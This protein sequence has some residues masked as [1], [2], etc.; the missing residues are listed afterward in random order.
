MAQ[1]TL[2]S[3]GVASNGAL[4]LQSNG[5]TAAVTIDTSQ[6]AAFVAGTAA[7]PAITTTGDTNTGIYFPAADTIAFSE[8][9]AESMRIDSS[10]NVGIGTI[11]PTTK[12]TVGT[13][14]AG[15]VDAT[16]KGNI[17]IEG[18]ETTFEAQG[19]LE[20]KMT[21]DGYGAKI[22]TISS[23][24]TNLAFATRNNSATWTERMRIDP[25]G[26]VGIGTNSP[27]SNGKL[28]VAGNIILGAPP[29]RN[30]ASSNY[31]GVA[32]T[33][34]P[35]DDNRARIVFNTVAGASSSNSNITFS[36]N[37]YGVSGGERM[38]L[39]SSGNL[40][41]GTTSALGGALFTVVGSLGAYLR[42]NGGAGNEALNLHNTA[43]SG[44]IYQ[45]TFRDGA[46]ATSRGSVTTNGTGTAY[47][48]TSDYRLKD[49]IAPMTG[50][51]D[52]VQ[53]LKPVTYNWKV[54]GT[55]SQGFIAH[56]LQEVVPDCVTGEKDAVDADGNPK[57]QGIDTS[58]LVATLTAAIQE[59]KAIVDTQA[60][61]IT[62]LTDRITALEQA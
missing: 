24:G 11:S 2:N 30:A 27:S 55:A 34:D 28:T 19:G 7:L 58:F 15:T 12:L 49:N 22:Q 37:D 39:D 1:I 3:T 50:A 23:G 25:S 29:A 51:L 61:T 10:G 20:F 26:N 6:R 17:R 52:V 16:Y 13:I 57:Y 43:T 4:V 31:I 54:D 42:S 21:S 60:S 40:L 33:G 48:T 56:E 45:I 62:T 35:S 44:T 59:L 9:G 53:A 5:T 36:T 14:A 47:N 46:S 38:R 8:G 18:T 41:V 32:T